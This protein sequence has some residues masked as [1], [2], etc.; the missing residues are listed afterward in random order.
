MTAPLALYNAFEEHL[1]ADFAH[2]R[3]VEQA[4]WACVNAVHQLLYFYCKTLQ[5]LG[6]SM[7]HVLDAPLEDVYDAISQAEPGDTLLQQLN[8]EQRIVY[9][10]VMAVVMDDQPGSKLFF[11]NDPRG[12][13][14]IMLHSCLMSILR[15]QSR[16]VL[17]MAFTGIAAVLDGGGLYTPHSD[18]HLELSLSSRLQLSSY[19]YREPPGFVMLHSLFGTRYQCPQGYN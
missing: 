4:S 16:A 18:Y 6:L 3:T 10:R 1:T 12:T 11:V 14:K 19:S 5:D 2:D 15:G 7:P 9:D 17:A 13:G 8:D